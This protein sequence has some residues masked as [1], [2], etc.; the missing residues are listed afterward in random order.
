MVY[1]ASLQFLHSSFPWYE[2]DVVGHLCLKQDEK[3]LKRS[4]CEAPKRECVNVEVVGHLCLK[5]DEKCL[6]RSNCEAPK[7]ECVNVEVV[8][9]LCLKQDD[10]LNTGLKFCTDK[11]VALMKQPTKQCKFP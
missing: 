5:Q 9:H 3:C 4:N 1:R 11:G 6:K 10:T 2:V 8:G 7:R